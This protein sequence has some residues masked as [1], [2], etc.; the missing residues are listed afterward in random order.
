[1]QA[2]AATGPGSPPPDFGIAPP[3]GGTADPGDGMGSTTA[4]GAGAAGGV[5]PG[6]GTAPDPTAASG[7]GVA[8]T[9]VPA[10]S[11]ASN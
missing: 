5:V 4:V 9:G 11:N 10:A 1:M 2:G 6:W 3:L 8:V 7:S